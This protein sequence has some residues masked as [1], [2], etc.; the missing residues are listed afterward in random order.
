MAAGANVANVGNA[1]RRTAP[2]ALPGLPPAEWAWFA[3]SV[4]WGRGGLVAIRGTLNLLAD[5]AAA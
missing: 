5:H 3:R 2:Q 1:T 4:Q